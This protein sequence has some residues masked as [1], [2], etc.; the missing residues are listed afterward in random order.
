VFRKPPAAA[1]PGNTY[2]P[3]MLL[4]WLLP[5]D[6]SVTVLTSCL[7][8]VLLFARG[9]SRL[10]QRDAA[11][12]A[13]RQGVFYLGVLLIYIPL[14]TRYDYL[15][16][17]MFWIHRLQHFLLHDFASLLIALAVP[18]PVLAEGLPTGWRAPLGRF[19]RCAPMRAV[20]AIVTQPLVAFTLF[21]GLIYLWLWPSVHF[22]AMLSLREYK[23]MNWSVALDGLLFW[24]LILDPR[25][26]AEGAAMWLGPRIFLAL[27]TM[28]PETIIGAYLSLHQSVVYTV[29]A[30]CGRLWPVD[31]VTDQQLGGLIVW[32][33][34]SMMCSFAALIVLRR[35]MH[36]DER[37]RGPRSV[38]Q[39]L[40]AGAVPIATVAAAVPTL[41]L[42]TLAGEP[43]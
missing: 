14:Q 32:I 2:L 1:P 26:K 22:R 17:H 18:W 34:A 3:M 10:K 37:V 30:V 21:V 23:C 13:W 6:F 36:N 43:P 19:W 25:S 15:A 35:W 33:P 39:S 9:A 11:P 7:A 40:R 12:P 27:L 8:F 41:E 4:R 42:A 16:Q 24:S 28:V 38:A 29:Y 5:W 31:A 20:Y